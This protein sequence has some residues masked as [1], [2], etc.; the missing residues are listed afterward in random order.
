[1][2]KRAFY[3]SEIHSE[4]YKATRKTCS[5]HVAV[6]YEEDPPRRRG[7]K[8]PGDPVKV[9]YYG[10]VHAFFMARCGHRTFKL[11]FVTTYHRVSKENSFGVEYIT[12]K[13]PYPSGRI[14][15]VSN[16]DRKV[17]FAPGQPT[18]VLTVPEP[19]VRQP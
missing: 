6:V 3:R 1:M 13:R 2:F 5:H 17:I 9:E 14:V 12:Q 19:F 16:I 10:T 18:A 11:A 8:E 4:A 15:E 7:Q